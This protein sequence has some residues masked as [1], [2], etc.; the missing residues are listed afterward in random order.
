M[1]CPVCLDE[2][3]ADSSHALRCGHSFHNGCIVS[4]FRR[5]ADACP[6]CRDTGED[7]AARAPCSPGRASNASTDDVEHTSSDF[8]DSDDESSIG[9]A[10]EVL[11]CEQVERLET[12]KMPSAPRADVRS[13]VAPALSRRGGG[14]ALRRDVV[15][16]RQATRRA[17]GARARVDE[18]IAQYQGDFK[19]G[20]KKY[21]SLVR[22][23]GRQEH[24]LR[25]AAVELYYSHGAA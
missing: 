24:L 2:L 13:L 1:T 12:Q 10:E 8:S 7:V 23:W 21:N 15:K 22:A 5:G 6:V 3:S 20:L 9:P 16:Y 4:W 25:R 11:F 17:N 19:T 18:F 14:V